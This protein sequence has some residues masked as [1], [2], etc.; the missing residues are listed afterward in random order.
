MWPDVQCSFLA[1]AAGVVDAEDQREEAPAGLGQGGADRLGLA[2]WVG[3]GGVTDRHPSGRDPGLR[4]DDGSEG[5]DGAGC[6]AG[7]AAQVRAV[8]DH[9]A[10]GD[11][12]LVGEGGAGQLGVRVGQHPVTDEQWVRHGAAQHC[13]LHGH[14]A[15]ADAHRAA[16]RAVQGAAA[17]ADADLVAA[18]T[19][20][21]PGSRRLLRHALWS[22]LLTH[23]YGC[24][25]VH[26]VQV[27]GSLLTPRWKFDRR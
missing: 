14:A 10:G 11:E 2:G 4:P 24:R 7:R 15:G 21:M 13:V 26:A 25:R 6:D 22:G 8:A 3:A 23:L 1:V 20:R 17:G 16:L 9:G 19:G 27:I 12:R 5:D 18:G